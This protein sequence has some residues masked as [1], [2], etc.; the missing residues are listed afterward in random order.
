M[1]NGLLEN[2]P[3][4]TGMKVSSIGTQFM[5][6]VLGLAESIAEIGD[7]L[8]W[9]GAAFHSPIDDARVSIVR[10]S[11][12]ELKS[13]NRTSQPSFCTI[14]FDLQALY[15]T[16]TRLNG[17]C[18]Q[19]LFGS[20][21]IVSGYPIP[22]RPRDG[23]GLETSLD[24]MAGLLGTDRINIFRDQ[25]SIKAFAMML[26]PTKYFENIIVWHLLWS[27]GPR[28]S[29]LEGRDLHKESLSITDLENGRH[30]IGWCTDFRYLTG[31]KSLS[32]MFLEESM[33]MRVLRVS[34]A[35]YDIGR[36]WLSGVDEDN[37]SKD[38]SISQGRLIK[39]DHKVVYGKRDI[40]PRV[41]R[42]NLRTK[43]EDLAKR[44][45]MLWDIGCKRGWLVSGPSALLHLLRASLRFNQTDG[46]SFAFLFDPDMFEE[47]CDPY[48]VSAALQAL[49]H[50]KNLDLPLY[51]DD[52][53]SDSK[54]SYY[55][56]RDRLDDL[57]E[58]LE[59]MVDY[60]I[61]VS[62][63]HGVRFR[64]TPRKDL[65]GWDFID[66]ATR[67]DPVYPRLAKLKT[68]GK[69]W[70]DLLRISQ[71]VVLFGRNFGNLVEPSGQI[72]LC[73]HWSKLPCDRYYV[74][75]CMPTLKRLWDR[76]GYWLSMYSA[77]I[78]LAWHPSEPTFS[79]N[80]RHN[81]DTAHPCEPIWTIKQYHPSFLRD[82]AE[83]NFTGV[84]VFG[85][86]TQ[87]EWI[88]KDTGKPEQGYLPLSGEES[89][90][91]DQT[92][93]GL[94]SS[95]RSSVIPDHHDA[96]EKVAGFTHE[97]YR[98]AIICALSKELLAVRALFDY[99]H[100]NLPTN[101]SDT[102]T[103]ALGSMG[104]HSVVAAC[105]PSKEYGLNAASKVGADM[106]K[107][108]PALKWHLVVGI[109]G[110]VLSNE[111]D[112]RL[113]DV[114][115]GTG[116]VQHDMGRT[117]QGGTGF[118]STAT[119]QRPARSL[120]TAISLLQSDPYHTHD[121]LEPHIERIIDLRPE[122]RNLGQHHERLFEPQSEQK[123]G[124]KTCISFSGPQ[125]PASTMA[126]S[127]PEIR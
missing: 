111:H 64:D 115:V 26:F 74:A 121:C 55:R 84:V 103:Y 45:V 24:T 94:G 75:A 42:G 70:V 11:V 78:S 14:A 46:L 69:G 76:S 68:I 57:Y 101:K 1:A 23:I 81:R 52:L 54:T 35:N 100:D 10:A 33:L 66:T 8:A 60:H 36:S 61:M 47:A 71:T 109:G 107:S 122:Y 29:Y 72:D 31:N 120:M 96:L 86:N 85:H 59:K 34:D 18:W 62:G 53:D 28:V 27:D 51:K 7:Q 65:E 125:D 117:I 5:P 48:T 93:S 113:G 118:E 108:F 20:P 4:G 16:P 88:W 105:L 110:G 119:V 95:L 58:V 98:V 37:D 49:V 6:E 104:S 56:V 21:V 127:P 38:I 39:S 67:E 41:T 102:N 79:P 40:S 17:Q 44:Q 91:N 124:H 15:D 77:S 50:R 19:E 116:V 82:L 32:T 80:C 9:L 99:S 25:I 126:A 73:S 90:D 30:I 123:P 87:S 22:R 3:D 83:S 12:S 13:K 43:L 63:K 89:D 112:I 92:D 2:L 114:V 106:E 97:D